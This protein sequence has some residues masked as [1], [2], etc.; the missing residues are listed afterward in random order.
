MTDCLHYKDYTRDAIKL[1]VQ[2][3]EG[4]VVDGKRGGEGPP[5]EMWPGAPSNL[6][7]ALLLLLSKL[8]LKMTTMALL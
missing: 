3:L 8:L 5:V 6:K 2:K 7:T 1:V 4:V